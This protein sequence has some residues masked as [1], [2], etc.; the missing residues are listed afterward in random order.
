MEKQIVFLWPPEQFRFWRESEKSV[1]ATGTQFL[2]ERRHRLGPDGSA[3]MAYSVDE[4]DQTCRVWWV[5]GPQ[6]L[7]GIDPP[8]DRD[9]TPFL[10][11]DPKTIKPNAASSPWRPLTVP[12]LMRGR[13]MQPPVNLMRRWAQWE[14]R[15]RPRIIPTKWQRFTSWLRG[16]LTGASYA[17]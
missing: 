3:T 2:C 9:E 13:L 8:V 16:L 4:E 15:N 6:Q 10:F 17:P 11:V 1:S 5:W 12:S 7:D 14:Y